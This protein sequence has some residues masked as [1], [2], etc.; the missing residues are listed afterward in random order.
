MY[1]Q[2]GITAQYH[3][4]RRKTSSDMRAHVRQAKR[5]GRQDSPTS[6]IDMATNRVRQKYLNN[7]LQIG[8]QSSPNW[9]M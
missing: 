1:G 6:V 4:E 5:Q 8:V 7:Q 2:S 3:H 9:L